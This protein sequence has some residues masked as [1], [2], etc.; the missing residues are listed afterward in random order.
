MITGLPKG[1]LWTCVTFVATTPVARAEMPAYDPERY[2]KEVSSS[3]GVPSETLR[4][5]CLRMEQA[6]YDG[7][8]PRWDGLPTSVRGYCDGIARAVGSPSYT[9]LQSCVQQEQQAGDANQHFQ[10]KR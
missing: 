9:L 2:C 4:N 10:F 3:I 5:S 1:L 6:A 7:L 8:K